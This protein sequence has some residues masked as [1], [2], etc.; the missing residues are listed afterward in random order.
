MKP[1]TII[2]AIL[3]LAGGYVLARGLT[4]S[5]KSSIVDLGGIKISAEE[6][7]PVPAWIGGVAAIVGLVLVVNGSSRRS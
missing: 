5:S 6:R 1:Q 4:Y 2:G 7:H 3:I